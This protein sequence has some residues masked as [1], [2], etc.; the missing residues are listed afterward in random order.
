MVTAN[1]TE[2]EDKIQKLSE[3]LSK[4]EERVHEIENHA[5]MVEEVRALEKQVQ[6]IICELRWPPA[7]KISREID[8]IIEEHK[9]LLNLLDE[10]ARE[11]REQNLDPYFIVQRVF[12]EFR[13]RLERLS[14]RVAG[15]GRV[16]W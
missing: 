4:L 13:D 6:R 12:Y 10:I 3:R 11:W 16:I 8:E 14:K 15:L 9:Q 5:A 2:L 7:K 1:I